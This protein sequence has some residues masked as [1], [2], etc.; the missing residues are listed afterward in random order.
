MVLAAVLQLVGVAVVAV[1]VGFAFGVAAAGVVVGV[2]VFAA[3]LEFER[4]R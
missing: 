2:A 4:R 1:C 3:G